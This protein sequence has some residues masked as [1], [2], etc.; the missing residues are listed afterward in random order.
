MKNAL[1]Y[2]VTVLM[3]NLIT[4]HYALMNFIYKLGGSPSFLTSFQ[5]GESIFY[6]PYYFLIVYIRYHKM[7]P[8]LLNSS[9]A[10]AMAGLLG[11]IL[12]IYLFKYANEDNSKKLTSKGTARWATEQELEKKNLLSDPDH[13]KDGVIVGAWDH[14]MA[15][16]KRLKIA[17]SLSKLPFIPWDKWQWM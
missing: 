8:T 9:L 2:V 3:V 13:P 10:I 5:I 1:F 6:P 15:Y 7:A 12:L 16:E 4:C 11:S 14:G 17:E